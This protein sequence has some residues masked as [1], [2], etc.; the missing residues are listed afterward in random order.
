MAALTRLPSAEALRSRRARWR[1]R[2]GLVPHLIDVDEH[3]FAEALIATRRLTE[4]EALQPAR[5]KGEIESLLADFIE[6]ALA[7]RRD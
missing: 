7:S 6:R 3:A 4:P 1:R 2:N 5:I